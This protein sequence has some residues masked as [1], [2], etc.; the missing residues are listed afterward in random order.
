MTYQV[1]P[2]LLLKRATDQPLIRFALNEVMM[3]IKKTVPSHA[4]NT[5]LLLVRGILGLGL[6]LSSNIAQ[7]QW[8]TQ[9]FTLKPGWNAIFTHVDASFQTLDAFLPDANGPVA[10]V[11]LWKPTYS[12]AQFLETP[13]SDPVANSQWAVWTSARGDTDT[14][15]SLVGN[16]AYLVNNRG[17][18]DYVWEVKG[19]P[20]SPAYKWTS[21]GLNLLGF[22]T[23]SGTPPNFATFLAPEPNLDLLKTLQNAAHVFQY[24]GGELGIS[25]PAEVVS[26][27]ASITPVRR[28]QAF[29]VR[30]STNYYNRYYGPVEVQFQDPAGIVFGETLGTYSIRLKNL[31]TASRTVTL[32]MVTSEVPPSGQASISGVPRLLIRGNLSPTTLT[33]NFAF[34]SG[35]SFTLAPGGQAGSEMQIVLGLDR[36]GMT[37]TAGS[38]YAGILRITDSAGLQQID[39]PVS[40]TVA[41]ASGLWVGQASINQV[42]QYLKSYPKVDV[43]ETDQTVQIN[44]AAA[45]ANEPPMGAEIPGA[46]I[47]AHETNFTRA[48]TS[49]ASSL[50]GRTILAGVNGGSLFVSRDYGSTW[51]ERESNRA[52]GEVASSA[53]GSVMAATVNGQGIYISSNYGAEW[54]AGDAPSLAWIGLACSSDG[55]RM[56]AVVQN[57]SLYTTSNRGSSW[58]AQAGAGL[59]N[60]SCVAMSADG[61]SLVAA[62][63][64]GQIFITSDRGLTWSAQGPSINWTSVASSADGSILYGAVDGGGIYISRDSGATW[65]SNGINARWISV[66]CSTDGKRIAAA[67]KNGQIYTSDDAGGTWVARETNRVWDDVVSSGDATRLVAVENGGAIYTLNRAFASYTVDQ[68]TG[69]VLDQNGRYLSSGV[70]TN[71]ARVGNVFPLRLILHNRADSNEVSLL[72]HVYVGQG[73]TTTN[74]II[75]NRESLLDP[76]QLASARRI[77]ATQLPFSRTNEPWTRTGSMNPGHVVIFDVAVDHNNHASNPF[78]HTFHPD[79]DNL[80]ANFQAVQAQGIESFSISRTIKLTFNT[81]GDDFAS[82]TASAQSRNG[83]YE[84]TM[85]IAGVGTATRDFLLTGSFIL[86]LISP[87]A[88]LTTE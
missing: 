54:V 21:T 41:N 18:T 53:D 51:S 25:N 15:I 86:Q 60:W 40:G 66:A 61:A 77:T 24:P 67:V 57:G 56:A 85:T 58:A 20:V 49:A 14:L 13:Y 11:W 72:Q 10:E 43:S 19:K 26:V 3:F 63:N 82:V 33:Y 88:N 5:R 39:A 71:L 48:Y 47:I 79:H 68:A 31:T 12:S 80:D 7:A 36:A 37:A 27:T 22:P 44:T 59:R 78:L 62:V 6:V 1:F 29:W 17:T 55:N 35:N 73:K 34:L 52:W 42:G 16:S 50:D 28:G 65:T 46:V 81:P 76:A 9:S 30:G 75:A 4:C 64:P 32:N 38:L 23:P 70:N 83:T 84:E 69:L 87:V 8:L 45:L 74:T 2:Y